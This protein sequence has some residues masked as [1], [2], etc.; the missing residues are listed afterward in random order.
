MSNRSDKRSTILPL[1][2]SPH[3]APRMTRLL[4]VCFHETAF[5]PKPIIVPHCATLTFYALNGCFFVARRE[6]V[7]LRHSQHLHRQVE[8]LSALRSPQDPHAPAE[9]ELRQ[10]AESY[11]AAVDAVIGKRRGIRAGPLAGGADFAP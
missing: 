1:P 6:W 3:W 8:N 11:A 4:I 5:N 9:I 7:W 10:L 2:S